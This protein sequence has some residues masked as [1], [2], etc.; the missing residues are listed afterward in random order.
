MS[1]TSEWSATW[2]IHFP[3]ENI[4]VTR[5]NSSMW[6][7]SAKQN[8]TKKEKSKLISIT[9]LNETYILYDLYGN[10]ANIT[11]NL[12]DIFG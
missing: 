1:L 4:T 6:F 7:G 11:T 5:G 8:L 2:K 3:N 10:C 9:D 12:L